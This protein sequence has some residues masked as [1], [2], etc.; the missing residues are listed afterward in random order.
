MSTELDDLKSK[1]DD[2]AREIQPTL[3]ALNVTKAT[4]EIQPMRFNSSI[5]TGKIPK[6]APVTEPTPAPPT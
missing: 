1:L 2:F 4:V 3:K 6:V 5:N